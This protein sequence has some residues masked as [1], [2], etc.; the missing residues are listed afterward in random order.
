MFLVMAVQAGYLLSA[1][2]IHP[3]STPTLLYARVDYIT[4]LPRPP[5]SGWLQPQG[6]SGR[7]LEG[8]GE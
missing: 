1:P 4:R 6:G 5:F 3:P 8:G 7:K 2:Q